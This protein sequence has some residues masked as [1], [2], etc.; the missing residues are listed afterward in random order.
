MIPSIKDCKPGIRPMGYKVLVAV[1]A[2]EEQTAGGIF[3]PKA[4]AERET[5][6]ADR[7]LIVA[8]SPMAFTGGD[9]ASVTDRPKVGDVV[10]F[11][12][13]YAGKELTGADD[14]QY[15]LINDESI[16]G[17]EE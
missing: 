15:R 9:W 4:H 13:K 2:V 10:I 1:D 11:S 17:I 12:E 6:A 16:A 3:L 8:T 7:G 14:R 5:S